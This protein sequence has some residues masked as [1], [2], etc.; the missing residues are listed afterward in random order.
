ML[1]FLS[2]NNYKCEEVKLLGD[3]LGIAVD[4]L[5]ERLFELQ[6]I[7]RPILIRDKAIKAFELCRVPVLVDHG[8]LEL[9]ALKGLPGSLTQEFWNRLGGDICD[10]VRKLG[11]RSAAAICTI[12]YCNGRSVE[13][14]EAQLHGTIS[15]S[16]E[17][18]RHFQWDQVFI[19]HGYGTTFA[20]LPLS[21]KNEFSQRRLAF[22][23]ALEHT[24]RERR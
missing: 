8:S 3:E 2:Q 19:P 24:L 7:N 12:G 1:A 10:V 22:Q 15:E 5:K 17:G 20:S 4:I 14:F 6:T 23:A 11:D 16:L 18:D 13:I 21:K 9:G